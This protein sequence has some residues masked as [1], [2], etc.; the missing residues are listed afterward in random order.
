MS[1]IV[2]LADLH[3]NMPATLAFEKELE[4]I[5][6]DEIWF[7]GDAV[8]KGPEND[9][10]CDWVRSH[11]QYFLGGNWDFGLSNYDTEDNLFYRQQL[12][13]ERRE[14]LRKL[15]TE[16]EF[17]VSGI[18]FRLFHGRPVTPLFQ[19]SDPDDYLSSFFTANDQTY[20]GIICA[21][22]HRPYIRLTNMGYA[23]NTGSIG[24]SLCMARAHALLIEGEKD[25]KEATPIRFTT[26]SIPYDNEA[27]V[28]IARDYPNLPKRDAYINEILTGVYSR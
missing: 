1:K 7:L 27:A 15:P 22:S 19:G 17:M 25:C 24:N 21:D 4:R 18:R 23:I 3:G 11:C 12:G 16:L 20:G 9:K 8:G 10:T 26:L 2:I 5:E 6:P 14:W 13:E 28:R